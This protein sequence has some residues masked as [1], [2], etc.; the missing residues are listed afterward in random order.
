MFATHLAGG[1]P[2]QVRHRAR[3]VA[4]HGIPAW[5]SA[6]AEPG[7]LGCVCE[8]P[9]SAKGCL[10]PGRSANT[11]PAGVQVCGSPR[12][13][14]VSCGGPRPPGVI[15]P[16]GRRRA[17]LGAHPRVL[18]GPEEYCFR[19]FSGWSCCYYS[20]QKDPEVSSPLITGDAD[21][22]RW[23]PHARYLSPTAGCV[24]G[25]GCNSGTLSWGEHCWLGGPLSFLSIPPCWEN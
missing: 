1:L 10:I 11:W 7:A 8:Q 21:L 22:K 12:A 5:V 20:F 2:A 16:L 14:R 19:G 17:V 3:R 15:L 9:G 13:P 6:A 4:Q 24:S 18:W 23:P 25:E